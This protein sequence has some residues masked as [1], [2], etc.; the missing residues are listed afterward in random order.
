LSII[1]INNFKKWL[2]LEQWSYLDCNFLRNKKEKKKKEKNKKEKRK[3]NTNN[4][5]Q[6]NY[7]SNNIL[8]I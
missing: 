5:Q 4:Y 3:K 2:N 1:I 8:M 7:L 6:C